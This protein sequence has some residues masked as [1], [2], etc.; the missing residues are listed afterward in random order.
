M[1]IGSLGSLSASR[2]GMVIIFF[3]KYEISDNHKIAF[4]LLTGQCIWQSLCNNAYHNVQYGDR[5]RQATKSV[6]LIT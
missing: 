3:I 4:G 1:V 6:N 5:P 2:M